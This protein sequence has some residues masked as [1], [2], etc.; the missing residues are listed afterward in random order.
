MR[1][2]ALAA[3]TAAVAAVLL[4][5]GCAGGSGPSARSGPSAPSGT[6]NGSPAGDSIGGDL[7]I[8][9][10]AS[11]TGSFDELARQFHR[12]HPEVTVKPIVYDGSSTL[13]TQ[14]VEGASADVFASA[15]EKNMT[16]VQ[17]AS[18]IAGKPAVF[19]SNTLQIAVKRGNPTGIK[20]LADLA[21]KHRLVVL[22]APEVPC[23]AA[24]QKLLALD[25]VAIT[26]AS[27]EQ[28]VKA[29][30]TK[31]AAGEADAG[32]VY[33][34]DVT[35][36]GGSVDGV[37]IAHADAAVNRY[38]IGQPDNSANPRAGAAFV[39]WVLS[40]PGQAILAK[41]GFGRP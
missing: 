33:K 11:L 31:V 36:S 1:R 20:N 41:Y 9:A 13:A 3:V 12:R 8:F 24:S 35:A 21:G 32:L 10:A 34:T 5:A 6:G 37:A 30:V 38:E 39:R 18:L 28:N 23:G 4:L 2:R 17:D 40:A 14:L 25:G 22:C 7:T 29:V 15:D 16:T 26:P 19:V 27:E